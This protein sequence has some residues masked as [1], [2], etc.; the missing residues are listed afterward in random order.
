M[1]RSAMGPTLGQR[2]G[3]AEVAAG[4]LWS[5][6]TLWVCGRHPPEWIFEAV[7]CFEQPACHGDW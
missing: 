2:S 5:G 4:L 7:E 1:G 6:K 3:R